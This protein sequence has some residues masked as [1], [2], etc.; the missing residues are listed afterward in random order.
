[1]RS[2][3]KKYIMWLGS[4]IAFV[5]LAIMFFTDSLNI[6]VL[7]AFVFGMVV[8]IGLLSN[9]SGCGDREDERVKKIAAFSL[10]NSWVSGVTLL[11]TLLAIAYFNWM[12]ALSP[13]QVMSLT[14]FVMLLNFY[15]WYMYYSIKGDVE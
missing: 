6:L 13:I 4:A 11:S 10:M 3:D 1:M 14:I 12:R 15:A 9:Y 7:A 5:A 2:T 8:T